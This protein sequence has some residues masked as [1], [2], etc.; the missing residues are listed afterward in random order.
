[1]SRE[2]IGSALILIVIVTAFLIF[3]SVGRRRLLQEMT[4][5]DYESRDLETSL[6]SCQYVATVFADRPLERTW[7]YGLGGRGRA[8]V[9]VA[10]SYLVIE[11]VGE[12]SLGIP[13][14]SIQAVRRGGAT[15][16]RGVEKSGLVQI[17]WGLGG[18]SLLTSLRITSDQEKNYL[19]LREVTNV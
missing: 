4:L 9:G 8:T 19:K 14:S 3:K 12:R 1:M 13:V 17:Q 15:I 6:F 2:L 18:Y 5:P 10:D 11:R 16:D 7:A